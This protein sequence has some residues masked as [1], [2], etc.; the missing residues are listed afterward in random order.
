MHHLQ[1]AAIMHASSLG[2]GRGTGG[3]AVDASMV[4]KLAFLR[5]HVLLMH[6]RMPATKS[7]AAAVRSLVSL[8]YHH[9]KKMYKATVTCDTM[10][11]ACLLHRSLSSML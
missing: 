6:S 2:R 1:H 9:L 11:M 7:K 4:L 3:T 5:A 10:V 8:E